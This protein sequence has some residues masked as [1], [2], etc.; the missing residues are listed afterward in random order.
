[1][2]TIDLHNLGTYASITEAWSAHPE[3]GHEGDYIIVDEQ[4]IYWNKYLRQW[5]GTPVT[6]SE[7]TTDTQKKTI[8]VGTTLKVM[9]T[10]SA[11]DF[12]ID[13]DDW[14][15]DVRWGEND[16]RYKLF[17]KS[18][19]IGSEGQY[20]I[21]IDTTNIVGDIRAIVTATIE[22][23]D[24]DGEEFDGKRTEIAVVHICKVITP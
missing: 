4:K 7:D 24:L 19:L 9:I 15:V 16:T 8:Y 5:G 12:N 17:E 6:P 10:P 14:T 11:G 23:S 21:V 20:Y 2:S 18:D 22:D 13:T 3:G 1:M